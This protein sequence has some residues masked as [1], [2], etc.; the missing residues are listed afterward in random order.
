[1]SDNINSLRQA[2]GDVALLKRYNESGMKL[3]IFSP[4]PPLHR[5]PATEDVHHRQLTYVTSR[6]DNATRCVL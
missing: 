1:M 5:N 2:I 4:V 3:D 6:M